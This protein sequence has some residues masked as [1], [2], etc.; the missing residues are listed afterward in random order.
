VVFVE[1]VEAVAV[2]E[3]EG[4]ADVDGRRG[5]HGARGRR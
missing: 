4:D 1:V 5:S 3:V 2:F